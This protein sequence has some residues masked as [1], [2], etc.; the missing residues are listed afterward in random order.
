MIEIDWPSVFLGLV[1]GTI[2]S[3]L[4]FA[5]LAYGMRF[6]LN[7]GRPVAVLIF[8]AAIRIAILLVAGWFIAQSGAWALG[9]FALAF[10]LVR[11]IA[12]TIANPKQEKEVQ[13]GTDA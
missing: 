10:L 5:G 4:F 6:A 8:S 9:S 12:T 1:I 13:N 2:A 11:F 7:T 3:A